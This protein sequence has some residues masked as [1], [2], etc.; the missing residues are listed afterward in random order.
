VQKIAEKLSEKAQLRKYFPIYL[1]VANYLGHPP[2]ETTGFMADSQNLMNWHENCSKQKQTTIFCRKGVE[3]N[4]NVSRRQKTK[5]RNRNA[6][7]NGQFLRRS[8]PEI[9]P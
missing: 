7:Q 8:R 9:P 5:R 2:I 3:R 1:T 4:P 6:E